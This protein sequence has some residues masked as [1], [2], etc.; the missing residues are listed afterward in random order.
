MEPAVNLLKHQRR[1]SKIVWSLPVSSCATL[2]DEWIGENDLDSVDVLRIVCHDGIDDEL[3]SLLSSLKSRKVP[4]PMPILLDL[5]SWFQGE[6]AHLAQ[7]RELAFGEKLSIVNNEQHDIWPVNIKNWHETFIVGDTVILGYGNAVLKVLELSSKKEQGVFE[8][9]QGGL[10]YQGMEICVPRSRYQ[11][12]LRR[13]QVKD[14]AHLLALGID[15]LIVPGLWGDS[16]LANFRKSMRESFKTECPWLISKVDCVD[17]FNELGPV[18]AA[19]DGIMISRREMALSMSPTTVPMATKEIIQKCN[20]AARFVITASEMLASMSRNITPTRAEV[21]D[22]AN[23]VMDGTDAVILSEEVSKGHNAYRALKTMD[24]I[25]ADIEVNETA[26]PN[27][28]KLA[29]SIASE[30]DA[31]AYSSFRTA[32]RVNA[33]AI[34]CITIEGNTALRL[35]SYR[36]PL[37]IFAVTFLEPVR[38]RLSLIRGLTS[39]KLDIEPRLEEVLPKVTEGLLAKSWLKA[40]DSVVFVALGISPV[41]REASNIF[42]VQTLS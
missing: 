11:K 33:K 39:L 17:V 22:V 5:A 8:V 20:A 12:V 13:F 4:V 9:V 38:R 36:M 26:R 31:I 25:I 32:Q 23:A 7:A 40:G 3:S 24:A 2:L 30:M 27:W 28:Q 15:G 10:V 37:P 29:P 1:Q 19:S 42:T 34:V 16:E 14:I 35:A 21:S 6:V 41:G 18:I